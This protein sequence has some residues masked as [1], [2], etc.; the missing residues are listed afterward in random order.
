[1]R[2]MLLV[3][4]VSAAF[5]FLA[6]GAELGRFYLGSTAIVLFGHGAVEL[7]GGLSA[8]SPVRMGQLLGLAQHT[9]KAENLG[10][11]ETT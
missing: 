11:Q 3:V 1:M 4:D 10:E 9:N 2:T 7:S 5:C 6:A 8:E